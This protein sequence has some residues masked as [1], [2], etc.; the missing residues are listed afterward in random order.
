VVAY[1][2]DSVIPVSAHLPGATRKQKVAANKKA[3]SLLALWK[4]EN[5]TEASKANAIA[6]RTR[7]DYMMFVARFLL[8]LDLQQTP[9]HECTSKTMVDYLTTVARY[10]ATSRKQV[11]TTVAAL[12]W[13][14]NQSPKAYIM[15]DS[16]WSTKIGDIYALQPPPP[17]RRARP[18]ANR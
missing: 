2:P 12:R 13:F 15:D 9:W 5:P 11:Q 16:S 3:E 10:G 1:T 18:S 14:F 4:N 8:F 6:S 7:E 17:P